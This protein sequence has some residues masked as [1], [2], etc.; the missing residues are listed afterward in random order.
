MRYNPT[1]I[2]S[3]IKYSPKLIIKMFCSLPSNL[4]IAEI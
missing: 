1:I 3:M 4:L 2:S